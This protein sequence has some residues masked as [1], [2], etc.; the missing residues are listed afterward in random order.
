MIRV[1]FALPLLALPL[2]ALSLMMVTPALGK[3]LSYGCACVGTADS[4]D[5]RGPGGVAGSHGQIHWEV[6][7]GQVAPFYTPA[8]AGGA[9]GSGWSCLA[10]G[11]YACVC[12][13]APDRPGCGNDAVAGRRGET[14]ITLTLADV[15]KNYGPGRLGRESTGWA[16]VLTD[17]WTP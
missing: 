4:P 12:V 8:P 10:E 6:P 14:R 15:L 11:S 13:G 9:G 7:A 1:P 16:C 17:V 3:P 5:C 2:L